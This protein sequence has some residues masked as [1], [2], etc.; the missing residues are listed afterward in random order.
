[1]P[2]KKDI[3]IQRSVYDAY[4]WINGSRV[5]RLTK[6]KIYVESYLDQPS[7]RVDEFWRDYAYSGEADKWFPHIDPDSIAYK[8]SPGQYDTGTDVRAYGLLINAPE[9]L[10][11]EV[12]EKLTERDNALAHNVEIN[13]KIRAL[14]KTKV[15]IATQLYFDY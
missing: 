1:M 15:K 9:D 4:I 12:R 7:I 8:A 6:K 2:M 10:I 14:E 3:D 11:K 5:Y 13:K